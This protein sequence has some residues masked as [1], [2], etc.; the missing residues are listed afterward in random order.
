MRTGGL[1][2]W[3]R[4]DVPFLKMAQEQ[5]QQ[6]RSLGARDPRL[7]GRRGP[8]AAPAQRP[9]RPGDSALPPLPPNPCAPNDS[10]AEGLRPVCLEATGSSGWSRRGT[11]PPA[12]CS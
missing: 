6:A 4:R 10:R 3:P 5:N 7:R 2:G 1:S 12:T 11:V 9:A 8:R